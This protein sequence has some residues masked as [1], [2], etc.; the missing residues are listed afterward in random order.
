MIV[1]APGSAV[2]DVG[3]LGPCRVRFD[4]TDVAVAE[5]REQARVISAIA[6]P[7]ESLEKDRAQ[8]RQRERSE[9]GA[10]G[11]VPLEN[12]SHGDGYPV[13][14]V[15]K[16]TEGVQIDAHARRCKHMRSHIEHSMRTSE[17]QLARSGGFR[18]KRLFLTL[19][20]AEAGGW[21]SKDVSAYL[22]TVREWCRRRRFK[23]RYV[24]VAELQK[25]G[26]VHYHV[27]LWIPRRYRLPF[28]DASGWWPHGVSNVS[29]VKSGC[30]GLMAYLRKYMSKMGPEQSVALPKGARMFGSGG[31]DQ[32]QRREIRYRCAP[33]WVRDALGTY[34]DI[35]RTVGGWMD[36]LTGEFI[37]SPWKVIV[38]R[39]GLVWAYKVAAV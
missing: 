4:R 17:A 29:E 7:F 13:P 18:W 36:R 30:V 11:L 27:C 14:R 8:A 2:P 19:T 9:R 39:A 6:A 20:Y 5:A 28:A 21:A 23:A 22:A 31:L 3:P 32:E 12:K 37:A 1:G 33:Y 10:P 16:G 26:A 15:A 25:R 34:A 35:R 38:D 24:W